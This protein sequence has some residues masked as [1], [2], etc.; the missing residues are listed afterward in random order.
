MAA[1]RQPPSHPREFQLYRGVIGVYLKHGGV[2][3]N[4]AHGSIFGAHADIYAIAGA[5]SVSM[6]APSLA[7]PSAF[8]C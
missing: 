4:A 2:V 7:C 5:G 1:S 3:T 6:R 8:C